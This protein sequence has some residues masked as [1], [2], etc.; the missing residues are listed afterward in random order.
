METIVL[1]SITDAD[2]RRQLSATTTR[3]IRSGRVDIEIL[4]GFTRQAKVIRRS[5]RGKGEK[6]WVS[7]DNPYGLKK[8]RCRPIREVYYP[9]AKKKSAD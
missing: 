5:R 6:V 8:I 4:R 9:N 3:N 1:R 7:F 2:I